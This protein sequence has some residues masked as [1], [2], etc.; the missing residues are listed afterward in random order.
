MDTDYNIRNGSIL[1]S[2]S[3]ADAREVHGSMIVGGTPSPVG[4][5]ATTSLVVRMP[6]EDSPGGGGR[7]R[8]VVKS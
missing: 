6:V 1:L 8:D 7:K 5:I 2:P 3:A 4:W